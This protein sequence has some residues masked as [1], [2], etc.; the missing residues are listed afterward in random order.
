MTERTKRA[1]DSLKRMSGPLPAA[2]LR[3]DAG[4]TRLLAVTG[5]RAAGPAPRWL[6]LRPSP[7]SPLSPP[8]CRQA[9]APSCSAGPVPSI[10][11]ITSAQASPPSGPPRLAAAACE[12]RNSVLLPPATEISSSASF[13]WLFL[14]AIVVTETFHQS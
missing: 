8:S 10:V 12:H 5:P 14:L 11:S 2:Q 4:L 6:P 9:P 13:Y 7:V 1:C 3:S